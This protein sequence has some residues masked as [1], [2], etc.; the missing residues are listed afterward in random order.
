MDGG[1]HRD[2]SA[3][4]AAR[5]FAQLGP[6]L[7][8][9]CALAASPLMEASLA[10]WHYLPFAVSLLLFGLPHGAVDHLVMA[11]LAGVRWTSGRGLALMLGYLLLASV[12]FALWFV[13]PIAMF[14]FFI[15]MTWFHWGQGEVW[16]L[17]AEHDGQPR[18]RWARGLGLVVRGALPMLVPFIA[19][20]DVYLGV[21]D[22]LAD[23]FGAGGA[24][25]LAALSAWTTRG[26][27]GAAFLS[28]SVSYLVL[29]WRHAPGLRAWMVD[30]GEV[31]LL[32]AFFSMV[33]PILS[34]GLYFCLWHAPRHLVRLA[35]ELDGVDDE[36]RISLNQ[37]AHTFLRALPLTGVS[38]GMLVGLSW[39]LDVDGSDPGRSLAIYLALIS[40]VTFPHVLVVCAMDA[41]ADLFSSTCRVDP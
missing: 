40:A 3:G 2:V 39:W 34:V 14:V 15:A 18:A 36:R 26:A 23:L 9:A 21:A 31:A 28:L 7:A 16:Y 32:S 6:P 8:I 30:A 33:P 17:A 19:F 22:Q 4:R 1:A 24:E 13:A 20:P 38:V 29:S 27:L 5:W 35:A 41:R 37:L 12:V 25:S 10:N 11:D